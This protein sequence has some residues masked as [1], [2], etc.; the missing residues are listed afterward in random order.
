MKEEVQTQLDPQLKTR[1]ETAIATLG[2]TDPKVQQQL[3]VEIAG[4]YCAPEYTGK[5]I[6]EA[7]NNM[8]WKDQAKFHFKTGVATSVVLV[9]GVAVGV[10]AANYFAKKNAVKASG[11]EAQIG[12]NE[13]PFAEAGL[14]ASP[15]TLRRSSVAN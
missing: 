8:S 9:G 7:L 12:T 14:E 5:S 10:T 2:I 11:E 4:K 1:Y 6:G 3:A 15:R 13:N